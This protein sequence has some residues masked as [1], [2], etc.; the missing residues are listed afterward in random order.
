M[1]FRLDHYDLRQS[2][3]TPVYLIYSRT[4]N[5]LYCSLLLSLLFFV[6]LYLYCPYCED[7]L[8]SYKGSYCSPFTYCVPTTYTLCLACST[9]TLLSGHRTIAQSCISSTACTPWSISSLNCCTRSVVYFLSNLISSLNCC[10]RH[11]L[12]FTCLTS[13]PCALQLNHLDV[14]YHPVLFITSLKM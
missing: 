3:R 9:H 11:Y 12:C 6:F 7:V 2:Y 14:S 5:A 8:F 13:H 4:I 10:T 1:D